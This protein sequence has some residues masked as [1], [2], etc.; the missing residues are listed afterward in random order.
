[1]PGDLTTWQLL[2]SPACDQLRTAAAQTDPANVTEV[3]RLR[4]LPN[5]TAPLVAA[6]LDLSL[7]RRKAAAKFPPDLAA[8]IVADPHGMEMASSL[9]AATHKAQRFASS[10]A[11]HIADLC[12]GI[13]ADALALRRADLRVTA[14]DIDPVRAWMAAH[15]AD[16]ESIVADVTATDALPQADAFHLDPA[17]RTESSASTPARRTFDLRDHLPPPEAWL[18]LIE[19]QKTVHPHTPLRAAIKL[20][21]GT[22]LS[23]LAALFPSDLPLQLE[24]ISERGRLTQAVLWLGQLAASPTDPQQQSP[25]PLR[26]TLLT[27]DAANTLAGEA[28]PLPPRTRAL[29]SA[30]Y[31]HEPDPSLERAQLLHLIAAQHALEEFHPNLGLLISE[32]AATTPWLSTFEILHADTWSDRRAHAWLAAHGGGI[33]EVKTR[34]K[35]VDPDP[36]QRQLSGTGPNPFV[37]FILKLHSP[38][39]ADNR[40]MLICR[41]C[42]PA[43]SP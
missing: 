17:R 5:A 40:Q 32:H 21:P 37:I 28:A 4:K 15:N 13:G 16:C 7:A 25:P 29:D 6:A 14:I 43:Q 33:V 22:D 19:R 23:H 1:M 2:L 24:Y 8:T 3:A 42:A 41:R 27:H 10:G 11:S 18:A 20:G 26:A 35:A 36:I 38:T 31:L 30:R 39:H 12:C 34:G 9:R